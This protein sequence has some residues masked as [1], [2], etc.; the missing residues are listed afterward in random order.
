MVLETF[1]EPHHLMNRSRFVFF[2][3]VLGIVTGIARCNSKQTAQNKG[4]NPAA[5]PAILIPPPASSPAAQVAQN[6]ADFHLAAEKVSPAVISVSVFDSF[7][8]P[9]RTGTGFFV[10]ADGKF[11]TSRSIVQGAAYA[12]AKAS[13]GRIYNV[14]GILTDAMP[15][16]LA[17][18][19]A[20]PKQAVPFLSPNKNAAAEEGGKM[21][22]IG[23]PQKHGKNKI[24][25]ATVSARRA[26]PIGDWLDLPSSTAADL[27]GAPVVNEKGD[28]IGTVTLQ[29]GQ[30]TAA[31][32]VRI[33][34]AL[35][36]L[37]AR[38]EPGTK[39]A[40]QVAQNAPEPPAPAEGP[41][42]KIPLAGTQPGKSRLVYSPAPSYP[43]AAR[44]AFYQAKG[45]GRF[46][47]RFSST[48][49]VRNVEVV[50]STRNDT[51]DSAAVETLRRWKAVPGQEWTAN[52]PITFQ[53]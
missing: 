34:G 3:V 27:L 38:I 53:P 24:V 39:P 14:A 7:G 19:K 40:W 9:L 32:V 16:D 28:V 50:Q 5:T 6:K 47:I 45:T 11:V 49:E 36:P 31:N 48:G 18:L 43:T 4:R 17:V 37:L 25:E 15:S 35:D 22:L 13:D 1:D 41:K 2:L 51:L 10:S 8:K 33:A 23:G 46:R 20:Q 44:R 52:V 12:I 26:D 42:Q 21:A 30:G 29:R